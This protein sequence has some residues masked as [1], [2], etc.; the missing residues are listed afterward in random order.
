MNLTLQL[1]GET[2]TSNSST[3]MSMGVAGG[4]GGRG[5][6]REVPIRL[7]ES[8]GAGESNA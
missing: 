5:A 8:S 1:L 6:E 3:E 7:V 2:K 4:G